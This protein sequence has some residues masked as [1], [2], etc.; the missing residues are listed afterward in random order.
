MKYKPT[1]EE[2]KLVVETACDLAT[3]IHK[4]I[5]ERQNV[6]KFGITV[7]AIAV[8]MILSHSPNWDKTSQEYREFLGIVH[9][10]LKKMKEEEGLP[11]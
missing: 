2:E 4:F 8:E 11:S 9:N 10:D 1:K 6:H 5:Y 7:I 3:A